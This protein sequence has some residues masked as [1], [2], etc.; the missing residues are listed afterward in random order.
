MPTV[1]NKTIKTAGGDYATMNALAADVKNLVALDEQWDVECDNFEDTA[2]PVVFT[3]WTTDATRFLRIKESTRHLSGGVVNTAG[4]RLVRNGNCIDVRNMGAS[5]LII[6]EGIQFKN[7][8]VAATAILATANGG[9]TCTLRLIDVVCQSSNVGLDIQTTN[10]LD[11]IKGAFNCDGPAIIRQFS[12]C[13]LY[14]VVAIAKNANQHAI[15]MG[16]N[17]ATRT[18]F[19]CYARPGPGGAGLAYNGAGIVMSGAASSDATGSAGLQ[20]IAYT[21]ANFIN[22]TAG[23]EDLHLTATSA[24][25]N[26]GASRAALGAPFNYTTDMD[27]DP[28]PPAAAADDIGFDELAAAGGSALYVLGT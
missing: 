12:V 8:N 23:S 5:G 16:L 4:Y 1:V 14:A 28:M 19:N 18:V 11:I 25:V 3:G 6:F 26:V 22:V 27:G 7:T 9:N 21:T 24:L 17:N 15:N 13:N 20:N 2:G 10:A